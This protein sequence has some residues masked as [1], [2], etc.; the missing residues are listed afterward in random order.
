[1]VQACPAQGEQPETWYCSQYTITVTLASRDRRKWWQDYSD[2]R[3]Y[4]VSK[5]TVQ[6]RFCISIALTRNYSY[7]IWSNWSS[8]DLQ[9]N[10]GVGVFVCRCIC[11]WVFCRELKMKIVL[12]GEAVQY[13]CCFYIYVGSHGYKQIITYFVSDNEWN[14]HE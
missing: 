2:V 9:R 10:Y 13:I 11:S 1:V 6:I 3:C 14:T 4:S 7:N 8:A 5:E 12:L